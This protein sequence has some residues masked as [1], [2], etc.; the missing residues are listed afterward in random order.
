MTFLAPERLLLLL[1]V[2]ALGIAYV[3]VQRRGTE[4]AVRFTNLDLLDEIAPERPGWRRHVPAAFFLLAL[5]SLVVGVAR[6]ARDQR[7]PRERATVVL[8]LD[9]SLSMESDDV[10]PDRISA[11]KTAARAF[12]NQLPD[13]INLGLVSF[14]GVAR[15]D[16]APTTDRES[17]LLAIDRLE[18]GE[19]TA[20]GEAIFAGLK[21]I[22]AVPPDDEGTLPPA[23]IVLMSDGETQ[24]GRP[25]AAGS[26]AAVEATVP[27]STI[28]FGT[29]N[30]TI[31]YSEPGLAP[32]EI[33][34]P[35]SPEP[36]AEI[37]EATGG[38][39]FEAA[40]ASELNAVYDD[41]GSS[42]G[43][44]RQEVEIASWFAGLGLALLAITAVFS[45]LWF[46]RLP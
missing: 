42:V 31:I 41:I 34:V 38:Q 26:A 18:L 37:A 39:F 22:D 15:V 32:Q 14:D 45:L 11:A 12:V 17:V 30:G 46:S 27:V 3:V 8:A 16:V 2:A 5:V 9:V 24:Q 1:A 13:T 21:A 28:V 33:E 7:V 19:S 35:V 25:N 36:L 10:S 20:I 23:R 29:P 43:F 40:S 44:E 6:P 4:Y